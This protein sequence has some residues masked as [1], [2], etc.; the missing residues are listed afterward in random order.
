MTISPRAKADANG[1]RRP[2]ATSS[3]DW[4]RWD[5]GHRRAPH[6][7]S[8]GPSRSLPARSQRQG[9]RFSSR[10]PYLKGLQ[11]RTLSRA[12][13]GVVRLAG[14]L[15][16]FRATRSRSN[17]RGRLIATMNACPSGVQYAVWRRRRLRKSRDG[18][19]YGL[20]RLSTCSAVS[21]FPQIAASA[22]V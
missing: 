4:D 15:A 8:K 3:Y 6:E 2:S 7:R 13:S 19:R 22:V 11:M 20:S 9:R 12:N 10:A 17:T 14:E 18:D 1:G 16:L 21:R 5:R